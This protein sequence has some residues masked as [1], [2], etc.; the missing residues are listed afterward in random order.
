MPNNVFSSIS[1]IVS[2]LGTI[3]SNWSKKQN[4][5]HQEAPWNTNCCMILYSGRRSECSNATGS[6]SASH[7]DLWAAGCLHW[8]VSSQRE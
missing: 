4:G 8:G 1:E 2:A 6:F 5:P 3:I 7:A